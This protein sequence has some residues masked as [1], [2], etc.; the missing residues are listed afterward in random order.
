[1]GVSSGMTLLIM[2]LQIS[3]KFIDSFLASIEID[4][5]SAPGVISGPNSVCAGSWILYLKLFPA[6]HGSAA[7]QQF[8][9]VDVAGSVTV[10]I[11][12]RVAISYYLSNGCGV[13]IA[14]F[15]TDMAL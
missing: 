8:A 2:R 13:S 4:T 10:S 15:N 11:Y 9:V 1:M 7:I 3:C 12:R 5:V 6:V 14:L